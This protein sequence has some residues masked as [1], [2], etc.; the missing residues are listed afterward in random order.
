[1]YLAYHSFS[2][3]FAVGSTEVNM[4]IVKSSTR[5]S[6]MLF[7]FSNSNINDDNIAGNYDEKR[8]NY[9]FHPMAASI[10]RVSITLKA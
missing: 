9:L 6:P 2:Q 10:N 3:A 1:M 5:L 8:W 7:T 4:N